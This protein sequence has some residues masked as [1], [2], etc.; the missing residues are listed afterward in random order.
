MPD[1]DQSRAS[2]TPHSTCMLP[3]QRQPR[4][5][6]ESMASLK[7]TDIVGSIRQ[8]LAMDERALT[9]AVRSTLVPSFPRCWSLSNTNLCKIAQYPELHRAYELVALHD[10]PSHSAACST[11]VLQLANIYVSAT[12]INAESNSTATLRWPIRL[13]C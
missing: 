11:L 3:L 7:F 2:S 12:Y 4:T 1:S 9:L 10:H 8:Q 13:S 5:S 6:Q